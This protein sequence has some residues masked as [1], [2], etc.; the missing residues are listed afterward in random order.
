MEI[1]DRQG[2]DGCLLRMRRMEGCI[3]A[4]DQLGKSIEVFVNANELVCFVWVSAPPVIDIGDFFMQAKTFSRHNSQPC[5]D[6][7]PTFRNTFKSN[8]T[9]GPVKFL[10]GV[11]ASEF[12]FVGHDADWVQIYRL[13]SSISI[14]STSS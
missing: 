14:L 13:P 8:G 7:I 5:T 3:E 1:Q 2:R 6:L 11:S 10:L 12:W 4:M 9:Q